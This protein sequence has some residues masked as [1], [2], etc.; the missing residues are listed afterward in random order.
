MFDIDAGAIGMGLTT[1][2]D[3]AV[4]GGTWSVN[5]YISKQPVL[6]KSIRMNSL[7]CLDG[8]YLIEESSPTSA[9]NL[10]WFIDRFLAAEKQQ[11]AELGMNVYAYCDEL[12]Q[13][14]RPEDSFDLIFLPFLY[15]S[16]YNSRATA[17]LTGL[18]GHHTQAHIVRAVYE[19]IA[20]THMVHVEKLLANRHRT[21]LVKLGGGIAKS[22]FWAQIFA[23]VFQLPVEIISTAELGALGCAMAAAV[24]AG[25]YRDLQQAAANMVGKS[26]ILTPD[27]ERGEVYK[28]KYRRFKKMIG[29]LEESWD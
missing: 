10:T 2:E 25:E 1:A 26:C 20:F 11:A 19:G 16:N 9:G 5:A 17:S 28:L 7:Y 24:A 29:L 21:N 6:D 13:S 3:I 22:R 23:D 27:K 18:A 14:S 12:A 8:Y 15:G 4:L